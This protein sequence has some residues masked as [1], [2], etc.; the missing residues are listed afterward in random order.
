[1]KMTDNSIFVSGFTFVRNAVKFGYPVV[2]SIKSLLP[3]CDELIVNVGNSED[4]TLE[5][6]R[7]IN[8]NK[9]K[10]IQTKWDEEN[11]VNG[12]ELAR[13]TDIALG[14]CR[15]RWCIYVQADEVYHEEDYRIIRKSFEDYD[16]VFNVEGLL[17]PYVHFFGSYRTCYTKG[18]RFYR[19]EIR[20]FKNHL[21]VQSYGDAQGFRRDGRKLCVA[22]VQAKIYHYGWVRPPKTMA[23]KQNHLDR[24]WHNE[25][26]LSEN[27][28]DSKS[29]YGNIAGV[30]KFSGTHPGVMCKPAT[31]QDWEFNP[32]ADE[33]NPSGL[34]AFI[35]R[36]KAEIKKA[37]IG[38]YRNYRIVKPLRHT[39]INAPVK[40]ICLVR[41]SSIGDTLLT[42]PAFRHLKKIF[43]QSRISLVI[44]PKC[45]NIVTNN[46]YIDEIILY[47]RGMKSLPI[48]WK[49][50]K[51]KFDLSIDFPG[52]ARSAITTFITGSRVRIGLYE[53]GRHFAYTHKILGR[54]YSY[55]GQQN[56][57]F[58]RVFD[59]NSADS[60]LDIFPGDEEK[61]TAADFFYKNNIVPG[62]AVGLFP[63][64]S[65][66][67][68]KWP[69]ENYI[70]LGKIIIKKTGIT[71]IVF[72]GPA[73]ERSA[74][75]IQKG[76]GAESVCIPK[77]GFL[78]VA[79]IFRNC[80]AAAGNDSSFG[81]LAVAAGIPTLTI[82]GP[83]RESCWT[84][85]GSRRHI[86]L[87][88]EL[89]CRPCDL[90]RCDNPKCMKE[91]SVDYVFDKLKK[92]LYT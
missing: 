44:E 19:N 14:H 40:K 36:I 17:F 30:E 90:T 2:E 13:Q 15:G 70:E 4:N 21:G 38:E 82:F 11:R 6:I 61:K 5:V 77:A 89:P 92:L 1:M 23:A 86:A 84:P 60:S 34:S 72:W 37:G 26:W 83:T 68:K 85:P 53:R 28:S 74:R 16:N 64:A 56:I 80:K 67:T 55:V 8:D 75:E 78:T 79:A 66:P 87:A 48:L 42:T 27:K 47:Y 41:I 54:P 46:P 25:K 24:W 49:L 32:S 76:I 73:E 51:K 69:S 18:V 88:A 12:R 62:K 63:T 81:H 3:V 57:E 59:F 91:V 58:L 10:I 35:N 33:I 45:K 43:P 52:N 39:K 22:P 31:S 9:I 50:M 7:S 29:I 71:P 65:W 20:A